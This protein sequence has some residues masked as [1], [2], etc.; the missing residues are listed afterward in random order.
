[1][2]EKV[3]RTLPVCKQ[4]VQ[5]FDVERFNLRKQRELEFK[6]QYQIHISNRFAALEN[7]NDGEDINMNWDN[8]EENI[9]SSV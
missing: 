7:F 4:A 3:W 9:K 6:K 1:V 8:I 5:K 2:V